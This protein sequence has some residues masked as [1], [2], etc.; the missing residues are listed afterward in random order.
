[1]L[2]IKAL[3]GL[4]NNLICFDDLIMATWRD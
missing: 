3:R 1:M 2:W 4:S